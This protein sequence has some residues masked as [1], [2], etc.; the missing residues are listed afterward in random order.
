LQDGLVQFA[1]YFFAHLLSFFAHFD[2]FLF[3]PHF[4]PHAA[5]AGIT[6][7]LIGLFNF[8]SH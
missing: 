8:F 7:L 2:G 4:S 5:I 6:A 3:A 1:A